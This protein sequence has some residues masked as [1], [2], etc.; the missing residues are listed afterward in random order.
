MSDNAHSAKGHSG[1]FHTPPDSE[2][3]FAAGA[4]VLGP[5]DPDENVKVTVIVRR[6]QGSQAPRDLKHFQ[7][8]PLSKR[9]RISR[10]EFADRYGADQADLDRVAEFARGHG[11]QVLS[12]H[13]A[14]RSVELSGTAAQA[15]EAF[16]VKLNWHQSR[17][18]KYRSFEGPVRI[19]ASLAGV[20]E[21]VFGLDKRPDQPPALLPLEDRIQRRH[22][23]GGGYRQ[24]V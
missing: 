21:A 8:T 2:H 1:G 24:L 10:A 20:I 16:G 13:R 4:K 7:N 9:E 3:A 11:I 14:R 15:N 12:T 23:P 19:P 17:R 22:E 5:L 18:G 6:R